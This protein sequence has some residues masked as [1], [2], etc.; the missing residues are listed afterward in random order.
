[1]KKGFGIVFFATGCVMFLIFFIDGSITKDNF[2]AVLFNVIFYISIGILLIVSA[3]NDKQKKAI[4]Q[5]DVKKMEEEKKKMKNEK[6]VQ[7]L[8]KVEELKLQID[9]IEDII[10][11][12]IDDFKDKII[13]N[14]KIIITKGGENQLFTFLKIN[15]FLIEFQNRILRDKDELGKLINVDTLKNSI[16][17]DSKRNELEKIHENLQSNLSILEGNNPTGFDSKLENLFLYGSN[18]QYSFENQIKTLEFY[19]NISITMLIFYLEDKKIRYY[20]IYEAFEKLGVFDST[21]QKN[22]LN[23]LDRIEI[24]LTQINNQLTELNKNF[25]S[26]VESSQDIVSELRGINSNIMTN[27]MLQAITAY[28]TWRVNKDNKPHNI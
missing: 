4:Q 12:N 27:N 10:I 5:L 25:I 23:K 8:K 6:L 19:K 26:L 28:Q 15:S 16:I 20:N 14:E 11:L 18:I 13:E 7:K 24:R 3:K 2:V 9:K 17:N 21:W 1:M 22:V